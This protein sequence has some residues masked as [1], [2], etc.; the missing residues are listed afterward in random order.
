MFH[1]ESFGERSSIFELVVRPRLEKYR[2]QFAV[3]LPNAVRRGE[4]QIAQIE[5][6]LDNAAN[7]T[8]DQ[9]DETL[10]EAQ[11]LNEIIEE[12]EDRL[13]G[14]RNLDWQDEKLLKELLEKKK[15]LNEAI[16]EL[17]EL[18]RRQD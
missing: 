10:E 5:E 16:E 18:E 2:K 1:A 6:Q 15:E 4:K 12:A 13:K 7:S 11:E 3:S 14:K 8:K 9:I 17:Q